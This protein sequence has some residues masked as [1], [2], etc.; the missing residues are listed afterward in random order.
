M[1]E[2]IEPVARVRRY[3]EPLEA[4]L[5]RHGLGE[6]D[7]GGTQMGDTPKI[8]F[9]DVTFWLR[10][11]E[12]ALDLVARELGG[13]GAPIGSELHFTSD[14]GDEV[15][16]FGTTEC[17]AIFLDGVNLPKEVYKAN[18]VN[19]VLDHLKDA[20][21]KESLGEFRAHWHGPQETALFFNGSNAEAMKAAMTPVL[22]SEPLCRNA[23]VIVRY[24]H[25]PEGSTETRI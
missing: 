12:D 9:V 17:V 1:W 21:A 16:P 15:R 5:I 11:S 3:E 23:R 19:A 8:E 20:L 13:L 24:G 14:K 4:F 22:A 10:A 18:D 25:H 7:G 2:Y 6:W